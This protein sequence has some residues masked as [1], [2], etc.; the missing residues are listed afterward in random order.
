MK[1]I[2]LAIYLILIGLSFLGLGLGGIPLQTI[3]GICA[4]VAGIMFL[5]WR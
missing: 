4:L 1:W 5:I 2:L 3:A